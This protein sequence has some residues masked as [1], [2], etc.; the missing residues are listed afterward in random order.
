MSQKWKHE[1]GFLLN[2]NSN[3]MARNVDILLFVCACV[4]LY[5]L[6]FRHLFTQFFP[7]FPFCRR[8]RCR[9]CRHRKS[10]SSS[11]SLSLSLATSKLLMLILVHR[12]PLI[13]WNGI[14]VKFKIFFHIYS[15]CKFF[16]YHFS[17]IRA[18][19]RV[20]ILPKIGKIVH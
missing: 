18:C 2:N 13:K 11:F 3:I 20:L 14:W 1:Y 6:W 4:C 10:S 5:M 19:L 8:C 16:S 17:N 7:S 12:Q 15:L 9:W